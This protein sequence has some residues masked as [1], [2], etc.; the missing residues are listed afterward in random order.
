MIITKC[1]RQH[2]SHIKS[3]FIIC[4]NQSILWST[5]CQNT[6]LGGLTTA[7]KFLIPNIPK[8][9]IVKV[10]LW[11]LCDYSLPSHALV[12]KEITSLATV[13]SPFICALN[14]I[15]V[16]SPA[17]V[18]TATLI[19]TTW[20]L[21]KKKKRKVKLNNH[22]LLRVCVRLSKNSGIRSVLLF[23]QGDLDWF[24]N[25]A[26]PSLRPALLFF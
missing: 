16:M 23:S 17:G 6:C 5:N 15:G 21:F 9:E 12:Y 4:W 13:S 18:L 7:E 20:F 10:P 11:N 24:F 14:T 2:A 19:S 8:F 25:F 3:F 22:Q 1:N 26:M